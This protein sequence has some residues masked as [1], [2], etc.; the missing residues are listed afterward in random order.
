M[1][2]GIMTVFAAA[3]MYILTDHSAYVFWLGLAAHVQLL[4][5]LTG[6]M[7]M[8]VKRDIGLDTKY[9]SLKLKDNLNDTTVEHTKA[10]SLEV[11]RT[12]GHTT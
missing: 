9:G 5:C 1:A 12:S 2:S 10:E 8:F 7:A 3:A 4:L 11:T 6:F